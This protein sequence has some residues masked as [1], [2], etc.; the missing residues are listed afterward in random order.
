M[1]KKMA[2]LLALTV[3]CCLA[4][5]GHAGKESVKKEKQPPVVFVLWEC[6]IES[7]VVVGRVCL[8]TL[9]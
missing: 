2:I 5:A 7:K 8:R 3:Y 6:Y 1:S 4:L 9:T